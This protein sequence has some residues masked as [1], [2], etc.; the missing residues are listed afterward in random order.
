MDHSETTAPPHLTASAMSP[1]ERTVRLS[2]LF[3]ARDRFRARLAL[4]SLLALWDLLATYSIVYAAEALYH[5]V[6]LGVSP[7]EVNAGRRAVVFAVSFVAIVTALRGYRP[8]PHARES[9][10]HVFAVWEITVVAF[11]VLAFLQKDAEALSRGA[12]GLVAIGGPFLLLPVRRALVSVLQDYATS[13]RMLDSTVLVVGV[14]EAVRGVEK[15]IGRD[16]HGR[17]VAAVLQLRDV[18]TGPAA[19]GETPPAATLEEDLAFAVS[20]A[21]LTRPEEIVIALGRVRP[22]ILARTV[23][24]LRAI[25][26]EVY[27]SFEDVLAEVPQVAGTR[28]E[29]RSLRL[30]RPPLTLS[31]R[32][33]KRLLDVALAG[34]ALVLLAP[35]LALVALAIR[36]DG[37]GPILFR[38]RRYG[39]NLA[40]FRILKFR[41]MTTLEDGRVVRQAERNDPRVTKIGRVLRRWNIDELPQLWNVLVGDMS[42]VGPRPHAMTHDQSF[43]R[44]A[45]SYVYRHRVKPGITGWAQVNG[46]RGEIRSE[47]DIRRR[48]AHDLYYIDNWSLYLD[49]QIMILTLVSPRAYR[50]AR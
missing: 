16:A 14:E 32:V 26:C 40:P 22:G 2:S 38:Q 19:E 7:D 8:G 21:R 46:C 44:E 49:L 11:I 27:V 12:L 13:R 9:I 36:L 4:S 23:E 15:A 43:M 33:S 39:L 30:I 17:R 29:D 3:P 5:L 42:L 34:T 45:T 20:L 18:E 24:A 6:V 50:N 1:P 37:P 31:E 10:G 25:P 35:L 41:T 48:L 47:D 28:L